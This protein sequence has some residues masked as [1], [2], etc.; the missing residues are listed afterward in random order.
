MAHV[1]R[2]PP[3]LACAASQLKPLQHA[4]APAPEQLPFAQHGWPAAPQATNVPAL[5]TTPPSLVPDGTHRPDGSR[6][7]PAWQALPVHGGA[8][9]PPHEVQVPLTQVSPIALHTLPAQQACDVPPH[10]EHCPVA[11]QVSPAPQGEPV[12]MHNRE[13]CAS[14]QPAVQ[15]APGQHG[16][17]IPPQA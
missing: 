17:A 3:Q 8:N 13:P 4:P 2:L 16:S 10:M 6:Q 9:A 5:H 7:P 15:L 14:Q 1:P 11:R 12:A